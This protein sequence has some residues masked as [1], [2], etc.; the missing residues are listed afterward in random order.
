MAPKEPI[1]INSLT[2]TTVSAQHIDPFDTSKGVSLGVGPSYVE[3]TAEEAQD[4]GRWLLFN[5]EA[6]TE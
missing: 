5:E 3:L 2:P 6:S 4:L 1:Y